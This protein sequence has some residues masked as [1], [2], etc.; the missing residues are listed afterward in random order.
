MK[1]NIQS[2]WTRNIAFASL[3]GALC[4]KLRKN[5]PVVRVIRKDGKHDDTFYL[6]PGAGDFGTLSP[7]EVFKVWAGEDEKA[8]AKFKDA[9]SD[10]LTI[11]CYVKRALSDFR[12]IPLLELL[13]EAESES[14]YSQ[15]KE[16]ILAALKN[17]E[18]LIECIKTNVKPMVHHM[19]GEKDCFMP[20][21]ASPELRAKMQT[22]IEE[23]A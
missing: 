20:L 10:C 13:R 23:E 22:M 3:L 7:R 16:Y 11:I 2:Y 21:D 17:R 6:V 19:V 4:F 15:I 14:N 9:H 5:D 8:I 18:M 12:A 1:T